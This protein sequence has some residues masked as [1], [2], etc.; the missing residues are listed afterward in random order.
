MCFCC[1]GVRLFSTYWSHL[2]TFE[3]P[4]LGI[5]WTKDSPARVRAGGCLGR[6]ESR[7]A[8]SYA[9]RPTGRPAGEPAS[10]RASGLFHF[11]VYGSLASKPASHSRK[12]RK[13]VLDPSKSLEASACDAC[14]YSIAR[15]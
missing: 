11:S 4:A 3:F 1:R 10:E 14:L 5:S 8:R 6:Q 2:I 13:P 15:P 9:R 12:S 7:Q